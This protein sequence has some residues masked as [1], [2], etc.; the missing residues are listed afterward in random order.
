MDPFT[1]A[2]CGGPAG[3]GE[4]CVAVV[5]VLGER[6]GSCAG[7]APERG[8]EVPEGALM[9]LLECGGWLF[10]FAA[11]VMRRRRRGRCGCR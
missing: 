7:T 6:P 2:F 11:L 5:S 10:G 3:A 4:V 9:A 1:G 8:V